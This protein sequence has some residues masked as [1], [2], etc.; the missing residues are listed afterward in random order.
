MLLK[1]Q[2][3]HASAKKEV[4]AD[5]EINPK[6]KQVIQ[7]DLKNTPA[8]FNLIKISDNGDKCG[9]KHCSITCPEY[10]PVYFLIYHMANF[11]GNQLSVI[12]I[13]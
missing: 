6:M 9:D 11:K 8:D 1:K 5:Q 3:S 7:S 10:K 2:K 4:E 12:S 13:R